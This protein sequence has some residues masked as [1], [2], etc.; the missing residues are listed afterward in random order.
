MPLDPKLEKKIDT[1][2]R[3]TKQMPIF[4]VLGIFV[5]IALVIGGPLGLLYWFWRRR[6][7]EA[8][9]AGRLVFAPTP[10]PLPSPGR[11][12]ELSTPAK[13]DFIRRH[14]HALLI[15]LYLLAAFA[16]I[17]G[18]F[19]GYLVIKDTRPSI[20][21]KSGV[22]HNSGLRSMK[23]P[24]ASPHKVETSDLT[25]PVIYAGTCPCLFL[26]FL[27]D[28]ASMFPVQRT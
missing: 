13:L 26:S 25:P 1:L 28:Q 6:L 10:P 20:S 2:Y 11:V 14:K 19:I 8:A 7:L 9:D 24:L 27:P 22:L 18:A 23:S 5:P 17:F 21:S 15:P 16:A 4:A 12:A 3:N